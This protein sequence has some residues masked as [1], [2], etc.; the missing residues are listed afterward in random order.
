MYFLGGWRLLDC[1]WGAGQVNP[2][3][4]EYEKL[5]N[6]HYFL[7][8]PDELIFTHFPYDEAEANYEKWQLLKQ[9]ISLNIFNQMPLLTRFV[10]FYFKNSFKLAQ[11][12]AAQPEYSTFFMC[13]LDLLELYLTRSE[14]F[15]VKS[16][17]YR[18]SMG[19][20]LIG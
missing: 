12:S 7:T 3:T 17:F 20:Y 1:T 15:C 10:I 14:D 13:I 11:R 8:D 6:E 5:A 9:P 2:E 4:K 16:N 18:K 19:Q